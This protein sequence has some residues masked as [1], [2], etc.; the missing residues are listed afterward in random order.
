MAQGI[1]KAALPKAK[2]VRGQVEE[3]TQSYILHTEAGVSRTIG[4][5]TQQLQKEVQ[6]AVSGMVTMSMQQTQALVGT[7]W[8]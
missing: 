5:A 7:V 2:S 3:K 8:G 6:V 1:T 4:E